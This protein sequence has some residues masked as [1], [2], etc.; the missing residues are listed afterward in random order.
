VNQTLSQRLDRVARNVVPALLG[1]LLVLLSATPLY[2][3]GYAPTAANLVMMAVFYW[4][5]HRPDLLSPLTAFMLGLLQDILVGMPPGMNA[6]VL[7]LV[8]A[9][10]VSQSRVFRDRS[11]LLLW[12]GFGLVAA[13][14]AALVWMLSLAYSLTYIDPLPVVFQAAM[15]TALFPFLAGLFTWT[16]QKLLSPV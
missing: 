7:V 12:W 10:G 13:A 11:F 2:I 16:Q 4:A 8:R 1:V 14:A 15:T 6:L 5:V 9:I 3:P